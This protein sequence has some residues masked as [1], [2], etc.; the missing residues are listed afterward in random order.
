MALK[1]VG[2]IF[3]L[4]LF[5]ITYAQSDRQDASPE[6]NLKETVNP[7]Q[8][9]DC[10]LCHQGI[11]EKKESLDQNLCYR[12]HQLEKYRNKRYKHSLNDGST[13]LSVP[14]QNRKD[15]CLTCHKNHQPQ[16]EPLLKSD[17]IELCLE[18][19]KDKATKRTHPLR[20]KDPN[21]GGELTCTSSC[22]DVHGTDYKFLCRLEP[23]RE[24][25]V[26]CHKDL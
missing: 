10:S 22:H 12:C 16:A 9:A 11:Y 21:T 6:K 18:C 26:S 1:R 3:I 8:E 17:P 15:G 4:L 24:L 5:S 20:V 25:C 7:H 19:H 2:L 14:E 23:G 13:L